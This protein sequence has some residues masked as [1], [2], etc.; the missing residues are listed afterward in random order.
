MQLF[1]T[2]CPTKHT[3]IGVLW[4]KREISSWLAT[5][6][7]QALDF[8]RYGFFYF[9][10]FHGVVAILILLGRLRAGVFGAYLG[11]GARTFSPTKSINL[12]LGISCGELRKVHCTCLVLREA[13]LVD[14]WP[15][16]Y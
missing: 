5:G 12:L 16:K 4:Q 3:K 11:I 14:L 13:G 15:N 7:F 1:S 9:H 10:R 8:D 6:I 2:T